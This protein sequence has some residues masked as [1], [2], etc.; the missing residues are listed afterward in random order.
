VTRLAAIFALSAL[1]ASTIGLAQQEPPTQPPS[2]PSQQPSPPPSAT[3][4]SSETSPQSE[5]SADRAQALMQECLKQVQAANPT[6]SQ[7]D[8]Q[9]YCERQVGA[10][11]PESPHNQQ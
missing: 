11:S 1:A 8:I 2:S 5:T 7:K 4:P 9:A 3:P 6:A 10:S